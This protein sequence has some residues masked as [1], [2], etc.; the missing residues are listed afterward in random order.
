LSFF[1]DSDT[2]VLESDFD[3]E[4]DARSGHSRSVKVIGA[5]GWVLI[6]LGKAVTMNRQIE[7]TRVPGWLWTLA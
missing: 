1:E 5:L 6:A 4:L 7:G 2:A 3:S